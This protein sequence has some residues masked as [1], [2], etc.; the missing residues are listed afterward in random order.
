LELSKL[1]L[2]G[3]ICKPVLWFRAPFLETDAAT[4][5]QVAAAGYAFDS[6]DRFGWPRNGGLPTLAVSAHA[7]RLV[8][9]FDIFE[10]DRLTTRMLSPS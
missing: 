1:A 10:K 2:E 5:R 9:D 4:M 7:G 3:L 6:S 8:S